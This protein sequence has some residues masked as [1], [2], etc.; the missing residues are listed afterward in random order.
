MWVSRRLMFALPSRLSHCLPHCLLSPLALT[1]SHC[2]CLL[3]CLPACLLQATEIYYDPDPKT[4]IIEE[5]KEWVEGYFDLNEVRQQGAAAAAAGR[6]SSGRDGRPAAIG[7][8]NWG[9]G[10]AWQ[11][12]VNGAVFACLPEGC[13]RCCR[14]PSAHPPTYSTPP[15]LCLQ[16]DVDV[17]RMSPWLLRIEMARDMMVDKKL[18][19]SEVAERINSEFEDDM[20]CLF[21][22]DNADKLILRIR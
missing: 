3:L 12:A 5:D 18:L 6:G 10:L 9:E 19:L 2:L 1:A 11:F 17:S 14:H 20:H 21:N 16:G 8:G 7:A 13:C 15:P 22:D 4:T